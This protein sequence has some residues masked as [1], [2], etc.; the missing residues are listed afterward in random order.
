VFLLDKVPGSICIASREAVPAELGLARDSRSL[1]VALRRV[2]VRQGS[3]FVVLNA[4]DLSL[5]EGF[6]AYEAEGDLRWTDGTATLPAEVFSRFRGRL[7]VV[8]HLAATTRYPN[9]GSR[10]AA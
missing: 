9:P 8:L 1:G 10:A 3:K 4:S 2:A 6:Y 5:A 7:E